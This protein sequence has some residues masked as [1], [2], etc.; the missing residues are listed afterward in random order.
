MYKSLYNTQHGCSNNVYCDPKLT[1]NKCAIS[2]TLNVII[3]ITL[4]SHP[5][6]MISAL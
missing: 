4:L 5:W 6:L 1:E 3:A 2:F